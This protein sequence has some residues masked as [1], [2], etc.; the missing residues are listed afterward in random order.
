M[1]TFN[2]VNGV[3]LKPHDGVTEWSYCGRCGQR[4]DWGSEALFGIQNYAS[5]EE[6]EATRGDTTCPYCGHGDT[7][8][9]LADS[10]DPALAD[11]LLASGAGQSWSSPQERDEARSG[12]HPHGL[13]DDCRDGSGDFQR[14]WNDT[15]AVWLTVKE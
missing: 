6:W 7:A 4:I 13:I 8:Y 10:A 12:D 9:L 3:R 11:R 15:A 2:T 14:I 1:K 5:R